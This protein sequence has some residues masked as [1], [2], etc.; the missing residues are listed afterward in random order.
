MVPL[1][2]RSSAP[3]SY[4]TVVFQG[5]VFQNLGSKSILALNQLDLTEGF[6]AKIN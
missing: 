5:W 1:V 3:I 4:G 6:S 2:L